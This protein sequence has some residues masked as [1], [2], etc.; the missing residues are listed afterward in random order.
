MSV[1]P[2]V[3]VVVANYNYGRFLPE[4]LESVLAQTYENVEVTVVDDGSTDES[5]E[6]LRRYESRVRVI[7]QENQGVSA[8]R[9]RGI[10][11]STGTLIAFLDSDDVWLEDKLARQVEL[12][13]DDSVRMV[14][15]GLRYVDID[16]RD[17]GTM[18]DGSCGDVLEELALLRG[19][20][21]P[22]T[23]STAVIRRSALEK[24]GLFDES[25]S[26]SA[27]WDMWRRIACHY[28]I[29]LVREPLVLY[30][31]HESA[32]HNNVDVFERDILRAFESMFSDPGAVAVHPLERRCYGNLYLTLAGSH[33]H[34][35]NPGKALRYLASGLKAW[36]PG[37]SYV[38]ASPMRRLQRLFD[39]GTLPQSVGRNPHGS[40]TDD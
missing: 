40:A 24:V 35:G 38:L 3:S 20:G 27:D 31:Q 21:V 29:E 2:L 16:G 17:L 6:V 9:N 28:S 18:L 23:G 5:R 32:M 10:A 13:D 19:P 14:Y 36:P 7:S 4:A 1:S 39:V 8:A 25:L 22:A 37:I 34:A 12:F 15:T 26:T 33:L 11:E 30:R